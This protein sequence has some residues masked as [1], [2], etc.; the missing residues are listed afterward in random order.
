[1]PAIRVT[2][3]ITQNKRGDLKCACST[4]SLRTAHS[5][6]TVTQETKL[7]TIKLQP[8]SGGTEMR[9]R[10]LEQF[11]T[12]IDNTPS[13]SNIN[14]EVFLRRYLKSEPEHIRWYR[15]NRRNVRTWKNF[16]AWKG[17]KNRVIRADLDYLDALQ[18]AQ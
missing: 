6:P 11:E 8:F 7:P 2:N 18:P 3:A 14:K 5:K 12:S 1:M 17:D 15:S 16:Q 10:F 4:S 9:S 13:V